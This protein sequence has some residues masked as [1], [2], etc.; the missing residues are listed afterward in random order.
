MASQK[1]LRPVLTGQRL[2]ARKRDV[3]EKFDAE[4]FRNELIEGIADAA[5][6]DAAAQYLEDNKQKFDYRLYNEALFDVVIAGGLLA[7]GGSIVADGAE[8]NPYSVFASADDDTVVKAAE[9]IRALVRRYKYLQVELEEAFVKVLKF[10]N[11]FEE[12]N[13]MKLAQC[14]ALMLSW[15]LITAKPLLSMDIESVVSSGLALKFITQM[16]TTWLK[17]SS[18][19]QIHSTLRKSG[20]D[21]RIATFFPQNSR[22]VADITEHFKAAPGLDE[23]VTWF[24]SQQTAEVKQQLGAMVTRMIREEADQEAIVDAVREIQVE[25]KI[26]E[27]EILRLLWPAMVAAVEW[28]KN[29]ELMMEQALRHIKANLRLLSCW[30]RSENAQVMLMVTIQ[31]YAFVNQNFLKIY[32]RICLL[33]YNAEILGEDAILEW[34]NFSHSLKG[35]SAFL[36]EMKEMVEWLKTAEVEE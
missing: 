11:G 34:Y 16:F 4:G 31:E 29:K 15:G 22:T 14:T 25:H 19:Q 2:K 21:Q 36:G 13:T 10:L 5:D 7:P 3:K 12:E 30:S 6:F 32:K 35:K 9:V 18:I 27:S 28:T 24:L 33:F 26:A 8:L 23:I 20:L 17:V 1:E